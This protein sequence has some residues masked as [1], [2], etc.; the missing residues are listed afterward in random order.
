[1]IAVH[2]VSAVHRGHRDAQN[3]PHWP[4]APHW[5]RSRVRRRAGLRLR[6]V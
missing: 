1:M 6:G 5:C 4:N 2:L 3:A